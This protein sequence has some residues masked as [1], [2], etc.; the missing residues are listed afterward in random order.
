M[1]PRQLLDVSLLQ[2]TPSRFISLTP[3]SK[4]PASAL[5]SSGPLNGLPMKQEGR[6]VWLLSEPF[7][8]F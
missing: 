1:E 5:G 7:S 2:E 8:V 3:G 4:S 6:P